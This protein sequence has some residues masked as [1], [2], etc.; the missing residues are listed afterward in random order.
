MPVKKMLP[1]LALLLLALCSCGG[2]SPQDNSH[3]STYSNTANNA[4]LV[5]STPETTASP[6]LM[7]VQGEYANMDTIAYS[8][9]I[10]DYGITDGVSW[11]KLTGV[12]A[13]CDFTWDYNGHWKYEKHITSST[14][15]VYLTDD[16]N[17]N[18]SI[19]TASYGT[20]Q[21]IYDGQ[22]LQLT[23]M[24]LDNSIPPVTFT[25][26]PYSG[27]ALASVEANYQSAQCS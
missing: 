7:P 4:S 12:K 23:N 25:F 8:S 9:F 11:A 1:F 3:T 18:V 20:F 13:T 22:A 21:G 27:N 15:D 19:G 6:L 26:S 14:E 24:T 17:G 16:S 5:T 10:L 2:N